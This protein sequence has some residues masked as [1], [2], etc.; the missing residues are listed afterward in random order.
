MEDL[1]LD[2]LKQ[3]V[4]FYR[5]RSVELETQLLALQLKSVRPVEQ[6]KVSDSKKTKE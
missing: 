4:T 6:P 5:N 3:L 1:T 2:E